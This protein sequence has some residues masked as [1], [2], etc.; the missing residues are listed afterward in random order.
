MKLTILIA[1]VLVSAGCGN[2]QT[3]QVSGV[4]RYTDG[5]AIEGAVTNINFNPAIDS[6]AEIRKGATG[7]LEPDGSFTMMTRK[8]G[9]GVFLG[10]YNVVF[11]V[12]S[13]P[14]DQDSSLVADK[15]SGREESPFEP[16]VVDRD[17][18]DLEFLL[19]KK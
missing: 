16:I 2:R 7:Y 14:I 17:I 12:L 4:A 6:T 15:Y 10:K 1:V 13:N 19:E 5:T 9:D 8:K 18:T 11:S 3:A